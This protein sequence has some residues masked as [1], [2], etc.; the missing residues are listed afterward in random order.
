[1]SG[2][3]LQEVEEQPVRL[4]AQGCAIPGLELHQSFVS[5]EVEQVR[6]IATCS[7]RLLKLPDGVGCIFSL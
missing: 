3:I 7:T 6:I 2:V 5:E 1:M 4:D